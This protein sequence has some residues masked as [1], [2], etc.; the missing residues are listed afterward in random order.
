MLS[1]P[2][3][4]SCR[5]PSAEQ[6]DMVQQESNTTMAKRTKI[7][8]DCPFTADEIDEIQA[9]MYHTRMSVCTCPP[10]VAGTYLYAPPTMSMALAY[11]RRERIEDREAALKDRL[12]AIKERINELHAELERV[13]QAI[14]EENA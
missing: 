11:Q 4:T 7:A 2:K 9:A 12:Q 5:T 8:K 6:V 14:D 10:A 1:S 13:Q 3:Y